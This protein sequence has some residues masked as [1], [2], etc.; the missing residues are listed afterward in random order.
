MAARWICDLRSHAQILLTAL[1][2][3]IFQ[4]CGVIGNTLVSG[5][6]ETGSKPVGV[7]R[8]K[9]WVHSLIMGKHWMKNPLSPV[10]IRM[11]PLNSE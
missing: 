9:S 1:F 5:T 8:M 7:V 4:P 11:N 6:E 10:Q 2:D 3:D